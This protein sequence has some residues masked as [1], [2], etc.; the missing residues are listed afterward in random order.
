[1]PPHAR[2]RRARRARPNAHERAFASGL[3]PAHHN[4][5]HGAYYPPPT[6]PPPLQVETTAG[7]RDLR[8]RC[9]SQEDVM[10]VIREIRGTVQVRVCVCA[11][12]CLCVCVLYRL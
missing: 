6:P 2:G 12:A 5:E 10:D 4:G 7:R 9:D 11:C 3:Q 1:M 8:M